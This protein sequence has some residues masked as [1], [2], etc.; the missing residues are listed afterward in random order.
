LLLVSIKL[1]KQA[2]IGGKDEEKW[3]LVVDKT[4]Y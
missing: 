2:N 1:L 3:G 4:G